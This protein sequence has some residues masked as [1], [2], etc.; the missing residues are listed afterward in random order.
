MNLSRSIDDQVDRRF[1]P[2]VISF[3]S[4]AFLHSNGEQDGLVL[5]CFGG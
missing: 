1:V 2:P 4:F 3:G 5:T